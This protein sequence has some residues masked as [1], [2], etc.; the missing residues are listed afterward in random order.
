MNSIENEE[1]LA[2]V[3]EAIED[4]LQQ[5][6]IKLDAS[7]KTMQERNELVKKIISQASPSQLTP[8]YLEILA[9][10]IV[11]APEERE[12]EKK[13]K[14]KEIL[15]PNT[16]VTVNKRETSYQGLA[17]QLENGEDGIYNMIT[18]DKNIIFTPKLRIT[19]KDLEEI[20]ELRALQEAIAAVEE[21]FQKATGKRKYALKKQII[22]MRKDQYVIRAAYHQPCYAVN[23][24]KSFTSIDFSD[25]FWIDEE[26]NPHNDGFISFFNPKHISLLLTH[27][28]KLKQ[29]AY[30]NFQGDSWYL[31]EAFDD[32][33]TRAL[34]LYPLYDD[35]ILFKIDGKTNAQIQVLLEKE[36]GYSYTPEYLSFLWKNKIPKLIAEFAEKDYLEW[37]YT[38]EEQGKWKKCSR[39]GQVK[40]AHSKFFSKNKTSKDGFYSI[41]K[42]CR[43]KKPEKQI[44]KLDLR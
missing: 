43:N 44:R 14:S 31:M 41:C 27:Y 7:L 5:K 20:P 29:A 16:M 38:Y 17:L 15:T 6:H 40:L 26:G 32:L 34:E 18:N 39:C 22:E 21:D 12:K 23:G 13:S 25:H 30:G 24:V 2:A 1:S 10:Y 4:E 28:S 3:P 11:F 37:H 36:F 19:P 9:D 42:Q 8:R 33:T 35:L